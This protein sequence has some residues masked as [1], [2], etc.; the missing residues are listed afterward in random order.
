MYLRSELVKLLTYIFNLSTHNNVLLG[1]CNNYTD[2]T[3]CN[4]SL[5]RVKKCDNEQNKTH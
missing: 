5:D 1:D 2:Y 3:V 4:S